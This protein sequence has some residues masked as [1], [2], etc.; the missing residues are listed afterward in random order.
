MIQRIQTVYLLIV[1][2]LNLLVVFMPLATVQ[3][4]GIF[5]SF[6]AS[7]MSTMASPEALVYPTWA[8]MALSALISLLALVTIFLFR[9]RMLQIRLCTFN[10]LLIVGFYGLFAFYLA[11]CRLDG[12]LHL[13]FSDRPGLPSYFAH[14]K[15]VG[16]PSYRC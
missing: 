7:G 11:T 15:L 2:A 9:R 10:T 1:A 8:L 5:Y 13:Q 4:D 3:F 14:P 12:R 6:D 16:Y